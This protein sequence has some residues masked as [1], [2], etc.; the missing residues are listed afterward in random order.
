MRCAPRARILGSSA[1]SLGRLSRADDLQFA[2]VTA[3]PN[4]DGCRVEEGFYKKWRAIETDVSTTITTLLA[5]YPGARLYVTGHSLGGGLAVLAAAHIAYNL[6]VPIEAVYTFGEP[7]VGNQAFR[8][9]YNQGA[10]VSWRITHW[11]DP[12]PHVPME[13]LG[14]RHISTEVWYDSEDSSSYRVSAPAIP[15]HARASTLDALLTAMCTRCD[16][17]RRCATAPA[18]TR[19]ARR[20]WAT[21]HCSTS[22]I[23]TLTSGCQLTTQLACTTLRHCETETPPGHVAIAHRHRVYGE[24]DSGTL[25]RTV[26]DRA[27]GLAPKL[28]ILYMICVYEKV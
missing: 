5:T 21:R 6:S 10:H 11:R 22:T 14:F 4:C 18:R 7:R 26:V 13:M 2:K 8:E 28:Y 20:R 23:T 25:R 19:T 17:L 1:E 27:R 24:R 12:V 9:F 3:Y 15:Q 16:G